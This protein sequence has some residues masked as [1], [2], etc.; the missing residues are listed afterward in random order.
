MS[1]IKIANKSGFCFGVK[2]AIGIAENAVNAEKKT[3]TLGPIIHNPQ[4]VA[5]LFKKGI[6]TIKNAN[7]VKNATVILR[8]HGIPLSL[9]NTLLKKEDVDIIDATCPF[10]KRA[11]D[12]VKELAG[13]GETIIIAGEKKHP[14]VIGLVSYG[15]EKCFVIENAKEAERFMGQSDVPKNH[16]PQPVMLSGATELRSRN[17]CSSSANCFTA[18]PS[19]TSSLRVTT[20]EFLE[21]L[22]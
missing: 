11:Q 5:R 10:V 9:R 19:E 20:P 14:E 18:D 1:Q 3:Y 17:I 8:T 4:E 2:R 12:I 21:V 7:G 13:K 22:K 15:G 6:K 16:V